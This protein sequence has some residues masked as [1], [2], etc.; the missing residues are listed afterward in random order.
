MLTPEDKQWIS[1]EIDRGLAAS[2]ERMLARLERIETN[3]LTE[4][5]KWAQPV[6]S[7]L[8]SHT[9]ALRTLDLELEALKE[10]TD[11]LEKRA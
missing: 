4:F 5:H 3:L 10:R 6:A 2:E 1:K 8:Q 7:R 11:R 9:A